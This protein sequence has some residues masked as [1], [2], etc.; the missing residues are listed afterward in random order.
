MRSALVVL[1]TLIAGSPALACGGTV[2]G[3][4]D[5]NGGTSADAGQKESAPACPT[6]TPSGSCSAPG[7][8]CKL[9]C[10]SCECKSGQWRCSVPPCSSAE[11][12]P[13]EGAPCGNSAG[14]C[15]TSSAVGA[16]RRFMCEEGGSGVA[17]CQ[18]VAGG[19]GRWHITS[20]CPVT[21]NVGGACTYA[22]DPSPQATSSYGACGEGVNITSAPATNCSGVGAAFE[23]VPRTDVLA[24]RLELFTTPGIVGLYDSDASCDKPGAELFKA[25]MDGVSNVQGWRGA[26][27]FP[28]IPLKGGH[29]YFLFQAPGAHGSMAC[30]TSVAGTRVREYTVAPGGKWD[31]P[32]TGMTWMGRVVGTCP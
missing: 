18:S 26:D 15:A 9:G 28:P 14:C 25:D 12:P 22:N 30:S 7:L 16:T 11:E 20:P 23:Y 24:S 21:V 10:T 3:I 19:G 4:G 29:K 2:I 13:V 27:I 6:S 5:S 8:S 17:V 31:G 1:V 32:F